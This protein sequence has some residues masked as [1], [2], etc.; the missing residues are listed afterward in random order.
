MPAK[1]P[2]MPDVIRL[3]RRGLISY[4]LSPVAEMNY[5]FTP[6]WI[7]DELIQIAFFKLCLALLD[8]RAE[9][10]YT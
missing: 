7:P 5:G 2:A 4:A 9:L 6:R 1:L 3:L 10:N 8:I